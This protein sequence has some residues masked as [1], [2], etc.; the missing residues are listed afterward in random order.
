MWAEPHPAVVVIV[1]FRAAEPPH[2]SG[3]DEP[4]VD[5]GPDLVA[6]LIRCELIEF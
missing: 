6:G 3:V 4:N 2:C 5:T 1:I